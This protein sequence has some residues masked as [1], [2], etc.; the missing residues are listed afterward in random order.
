MRLNMLRLVWEAT[1]G[2]GFSSPMLATTRTWVLAFGTKTSVQPHGAWTTSWLTNFPRRFHESHSSGV[3]FDIRI[4]N[5]F[6]R[7]GEGGAFIQVGKRGPGCLGLMAP[8]VNQPRLTSLSTDFGIWPV[9]AKPY[10]LRDSWSQR[11]QGKGRVQPHPL[12]AHQGSVS[13][14]I[15]SRLVRVGKVVHPCRVIIF[16]KAVSMVMDDL[17]MD[18]R[19]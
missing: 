10:L 7:G 11:K 14:G 6:E 1:V 16:R 13:S 19:S 2:C 5:I 9:M 12:S 18:G 4:E 15:K 3:P 8:L 17:G